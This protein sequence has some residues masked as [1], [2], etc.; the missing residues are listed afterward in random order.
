MNFGIKDL[1]QIHYGAHGHWWISDKRLLA[2]L[3]KWDC[4]LSKLVRAFL[5]TSDVN[6][7]F[8]IW[9]K[10]VEYI[11][12]SVGGRI[13]I[14]KHENLSPVSEQGIKDIS[15]IIKKLS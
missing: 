3:D 5:A 12:E 7:K 10:I 6:K 4:K 9:S 11:Y 14:S 2:D 13:D 15:S 1:L 8:G